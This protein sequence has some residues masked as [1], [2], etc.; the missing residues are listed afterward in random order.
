[1]YN[2]TYEAAVMATSESEGD[3]IHLTECSRHYV[4]MHI[5][6]TRRNTQDFIG[7]EDKMR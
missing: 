1:M 5:V 2:I 4:I 6:R 3:Q 7:H